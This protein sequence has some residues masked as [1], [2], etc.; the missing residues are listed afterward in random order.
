MCVNQNCFNYFLGKRKRAWE[1]QKASLSKFDQIN[2]LPTLK[3]RVASL[4]NIHSQVLQNVVERVDLAMQAFFRVENPK[5]FRAEDQSTKRNWL[6]FNAS[7]PK[8]KRV[9]RSVR[10]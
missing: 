4:K 6:K 1:E 3:E 9:V 5:F 10:Q 2:T 8:R 7:S